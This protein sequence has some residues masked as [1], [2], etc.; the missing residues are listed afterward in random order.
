MIILASGSWLRKTIMQASEFTFE[1]K[2]K[3][4]DERK[5][6]SLYHGKGHAEV[7]EMLAQAKAS[8]VASDYPD[9]LVIGADTFVVLPNG[10]RG[11]KP[12]TKAEAFEV[13]LAQ[14]GKKAT[15]YT[16]IAVCYKGKIATATVSAVITYSKFGKSQL[17]LL[18]QKDDPTIRNAGLGFFM[19][20]P[21]FTLVETFEGSYTGAMGLPMD[22]VRQLM[23]EVDFFA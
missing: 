12:K 16:G 4:V 6:E 2:T 21:G 3:D 20:A 1:V 13:C 8:A 10:E 22:E 11:H 19:D 15:V 23:Q 5:I 9:D 7:V 17:E 14:S 18:F